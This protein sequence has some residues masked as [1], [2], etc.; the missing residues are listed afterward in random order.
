M[1]L[2]A[3]PALDD[4]STVS[5]P[6]VEIPQADQCLQELQLQVNPLDPLADSDFGIA[7]YTGALQILNEIVGI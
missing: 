6:R 7:C 4:D 3:P 1:D 5:V 2:S